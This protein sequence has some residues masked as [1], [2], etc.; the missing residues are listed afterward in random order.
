MT[1]LPT[2]ANSLRKP[3]TGVTS[4]R[5]VRV[6]V[7]DDVDELRRT[8]MQG[9]SLL[10][11][12]VDQA[13][14][15]QEATEKVREGTVN[16]VILDLHMP[17]MDGLACLKAIKEERADTEVLIV[18][19]YGTIPSAVEAMRLGAYDY[20]AKPFSFDELDQRLKRCMHARE[21]RREN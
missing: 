8:Y 16:A 7:V 19:G 9:L 17:G 18:T 1:E 11:Y 6:L 3:S 20:I 12:D 5:E 10:G 14:S 13:R 4:G 15:G 2:Q 21:L